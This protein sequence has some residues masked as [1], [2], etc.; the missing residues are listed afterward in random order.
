MKKVAHRTPNYK[1]GNVASGNTI[2]A[3]RGVNNANNQDI[4]TIGTNILKSIGRY[5]EN[6][7]QI[8][9]FIEE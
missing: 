2:A 4:T 9:P 7:K 8:K 6:T 1:F 5:D 3:Q